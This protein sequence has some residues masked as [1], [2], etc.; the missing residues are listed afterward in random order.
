MQVHVLDAT[1]SATRLCWFPVLYAFWQRCSDREQTWN[2]NLAGVQRQSMARQFKYKVLPWIQCEGRLLYLKGNPL[3]FQSRC[4]LPTCSMNTCLFIFI[5]SSVIYNVISDLKE[6]CE[7]WKINRWMACNVL[8]KAAFGG[9]CFEWHFKSG[10]KTLKTVMIAPKQVLI[11]FIF[12]F[13]QFSTTSTEFGRKKYLLPP[14]DLN[15]TGQQILTYDPDLSLILIKSCFTEVLY[16]FKVLQ[17]SCLIMKNLHKYLCS[18]AVTNSS[19]YLQKKTG[20]SRVCQLKR[21][22][23]LYIVLA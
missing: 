23:H 6:H 16:I 13:L 11:F 14:H 15:W 8:T 9:F 4:P 3:S 21:I 20:E 7:A 19:I 12:I 10:L 17:T 18:A 2:H 5:K 22:L 1:Y